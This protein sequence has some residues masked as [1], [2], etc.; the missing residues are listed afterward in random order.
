VLT[1]LNRRAEAIRD[2]E[3]ALNFAASEED[4]AAIESRIQKLQPH[5]V[6]KQAAGY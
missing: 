1:D 4:K 5:S 2:L 6:E 3:T